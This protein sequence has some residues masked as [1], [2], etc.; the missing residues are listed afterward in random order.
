MSWLSSLTSG[1]GAAALTSLVKQAVS[2]VE[3]SI[4][5]VLDIQ[6]AAG[7]DKASLSGLLEFGSGF[8][9]GTGAGPASGSP[10]A[11]R[12]KQV[13][14]QHA[15]S[16]ASVATAPPAQAGTGSPA[17]GQP[18]KQGDFFADMLGGKATPNA[19][20]KQAAPAV[21]ELIS[22][23]KTL[24]QRETQL[25]NASQENAG[26]LD[27]TTQL[28]TL[29]VDAQHKHAQDTI[30]FEHA[31]AELRARISELESQVAAL[32]AECAKLR[33]ESGASSRAGDL[34]RALAEKEESIRGLLAEGENL[35]KEI[36]KANTTVK[37]LRAR[38]SELDKEVKDAQK[39]LESA[40][41]EISVLKEK[42]AKVGESEQSLSGI[43]LPLPIDRFDRVV[44]LEK[45]LSAA[46][47]KCAELQVQFE[48]VS[49][50]LEALRE[51][52]SD[53]KIA[54]QSEA[55]EKE[56]SDFFRTR[57]RNLFSGPVLTANVDCKMRA[58]QEVYSQ[59]EQVRQ[60]AEQVESALRQ[61][62]F[63]LRASL[64]R[65]D[66]DAAWKEETLREE[67]QAMQMRLQAAESRNEDLSVL[68]QDTTK[69]LMRQIDLL[70]AQHSK[71]LKDWEAA[72]RSLTKRLYDAEAERSAAL[73]NERLLKERLS[74]LTERGRAVSLEKQLRELN[75]RLGQSADLHA[76]EMAR[77]RQEAEDRLE[78]K[79][80]EESANWEARLKTEQRLRQ[81]QAE[82]LGSLRVDSRPRLSATSLPESDESHN[83]ALEMLGEKTERVLEL[84]ADIDDMK[85]AFKAQIESLLAKSK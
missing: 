81:Q 21:A 10:S 66:E 82:R 5:K 17:G 65:S 51:Q 33:H 60:Q 72:E 67:I 13:A 40:T 71:A 56:V 50:E 74:E 26:L 62:I 19:P 54:A 47:D 44:R 37:K 58:N 43:C 77:V 61:E 32:Q 64:L 30:A 59:L 68:G 28:K 42:L 48:S 85:A 4:D 12:R 22:L 70:Q 23:H 7:E 6:P 9:P 24:S 29:L 69:P 35:A 75:A 39:K 11:S 27:Q 80:Q 63:E 3:S 20:P 2:S 34:S 31:V 1:E 25:L 46:R 18:A 84:E 45:D 36:L 41:A 16:Q 49:K 83:T 73:E 79:L 38:E 14:E 57:T 52:D 55:L 8:I 76:A 78:A 15:A 53:A